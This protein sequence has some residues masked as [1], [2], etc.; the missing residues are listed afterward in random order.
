M[1]RGS[2]STLPSPAS[3]LT[4]FWLMSGVAQKPLDFK[5]TEH[6][7]SRSTSKFN[8]YGD[9]PRFF[10]A[11]SRCCPPRETKQE[12]IPSGNSVVFSRLA[13]IRTRRRREDHHCSMMPN[14]RFCHAYCIMSRHVTSCDSARRLSHPTPPH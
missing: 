8:T 3:K 1:K 10:K 9:H 5:M 6:R 2:L 7:S 4:I 13:P 11:E 12:P 14:F